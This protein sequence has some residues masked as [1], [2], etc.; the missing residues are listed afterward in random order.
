[1]CREESLTSET[2]Y[3]GHRKNLSAIGDVVKYG[4]AR[5]IPR[6]V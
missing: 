1:M 2:R 3:W 4:V 5:G 6:P